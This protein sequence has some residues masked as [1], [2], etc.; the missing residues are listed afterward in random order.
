M[1]DEVSTETEQ[2]EVKAKSG[3][4][5]RAVPSHS[6]E[7]DMS[8]AWD[9]TVQYR[10]M[11][12]PATPAYYNRLFA[13]Q[14]PNS[15]GDRKTHY[16]FVHHFV[17]ENQ[18]PGAAS[19]RALANAVAVLNG[20]RSGTVLRGAARE[21]VY[22]HIA[23]H[24]EDAGRD[25]PEL[26]S[27]EDVDA[28]MMYKGLIDAPLT[29]DT[30]IDEI[31]HVE[32]DTVV[33]YELDGKIMAGVVLD[34]NDE[35]DTVEVQE[36]NMESGEL[37][38]TKSV[39]EYGDIKVRTFTVMEKSEYDIE[40]GSVVSWDTTQG[41]FYGDVVDI[42]TEGEARGEPQGLVLEGTADEPVF[43]IRVWMQEEYQEPQAEDEPA[44]EVVPEEEDSMHRKNG[45]EWHPTNVTVVARGAGLRVEEALPQAAPSSDY[46]EENTPEETPMKNISTDVQA[47]IEEL[48]KATNE[49]VAALAE[50]KA[51][52]QVTE[53]AA[54]TEVKADETPAEEKAEEAVVETPAPEVVEEVKATEETA[55]PAETTEV[56][57]EKAEEQPVVEETA[58]IETP[59]LS[60]DDLKAFHDLIKSVTK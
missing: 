4:N 43:V 11:R 44:E 27:D 3:P 14:I 55:A 23:A 39:I 24:Y 36:I 32:I 6:T 38:E 46:D 33:R 37:T 40:A 22:R 7:V 49:I 2:T 47:K 10:K 16:S 29:A 51:E 48:L 21:G 25:V 30:T 20:G 57:E 45:G 15:D 18:E 9:R 17:G 1:S 12:S 42:V 56:V 53:V 34:I 31:E 50:A 35:T 60:F 28:I 41:R 5:G 19:M 58:A 59:T 54:E 13:Y 52:E 26:K 8:S